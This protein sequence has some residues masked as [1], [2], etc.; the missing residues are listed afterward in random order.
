MT[1]FLWCLN[2]LML[3]KPVT[4]APGCRV[5]YIS[6]LKALAVDV[7]RN[8]RLPL[9]GIANM[10]RH[11]SVLST[12]RKLRSARG[13]HR[14][15]NE[16][17]PATSRRDSDHDTG[18]AVPAADLGRR[19][20]LRQVDTVIV[21]EIHALVPTKRGAHLAP[22]EPSRLTEGRIQ[23]IGLRYPAPT[24]R[25]GAFPGGNGPVRRRG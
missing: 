20:E 2:R 19:L 18:V 7:E 25:G 21:D 3:A 6:P 24:G 5:I 11:G 4:E 22:V 14:N 16:P 1:A 15:G 9:A 17:L 13:T 12:S 23:R 8:L 10:A